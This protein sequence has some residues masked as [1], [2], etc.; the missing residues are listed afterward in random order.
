[1]AKLWP[2]LIAGLIAAVAGLVFLPTHALMGAA[3]FALALWLI[4]GSATDLGRR[5]RW[6]KGGAKPALERLARIPAPTIGYL[7][8]HAGLGVLLLGIAGVTA[9]QQE[10][11][12]ALAPGEQMRL[13]ALTLTLDDV[14][15]VP[16]PDYIAERG[17]IRVEKDGV[18]IARMAPGR[19][20][21]PVQGR[22]TTEAAI[23][24]NILRDLYIV[25]GEGQGGRYAVHAYIN[26]L[27]PLIWIGA[28]IAALGGAVSLL[29]RR[30]AVLGRVAL[31]PAS[32]EAAAAE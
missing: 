18:L 2:A 7:V 21:Y 13:G 6:G 1:L 26:P 3:G 15:T 4:G 31:A 24:T 16:G 8:A 30:R 22:A 20:F 19:R 27:A 29:A 25:I 32:A 14:A 23:R 5:L 10:A 9:G 12:A 28:A 17:L 11:L